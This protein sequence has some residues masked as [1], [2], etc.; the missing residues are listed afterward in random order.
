[1]WQRLADQIDTASL[2]PLGGVNPAYDDDQTAIVARHE[3][4]QAER[5]AAAGPQMLYPSATVFQE[6]FS[7]C[8]VPGPFTDPRLLR[9]R[10]SPL[11]RG[12]CHLRLGRG[13]GPSA[14]QLG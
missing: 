8:G 5:P 2:L 7:T 1:M 13:R 3:Q 6:I 11:R 10:R 12:V 9:R 4:R 14:L